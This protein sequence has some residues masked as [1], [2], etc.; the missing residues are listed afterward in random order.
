MTTVAPERRRF[1]DIVPMLLLTLLGVALLFYFTRTGLA[2][3]GD[4]VRYVMGAENLIAGRGYSRTS[5]GGEVYPETGFAPFLAV[6]LA[7]MG[8]LGADMFDGARV[9]NLLLFGLNIL[10]V[11]AMI[12]RHTGSWLAA[13]LGGMLFLAA[14][15]VLESHAWLMTE[16]LF[17][18]VILLSLASLLHFLDTGRI[19]FLILS[20][21]LAGA[22]SV[23]RYIGLSVAPAGALAVLWLGRGPWRARLTQAFGFAALG[24]A[25][26]LV[27][28]LRNQ[29]VADSGLANR[30]LIFHMIRPDL[31]RFYLYEAATWAL[32]DPFVVPRAVRAAIAVALTGLAPAWYFLRARQERRLSLAPTS[33]AFGALPWVFGVN[34]VSYSVV[35]ILNSILLDA[36]TTEPAATRYLVPFFG[37]LVVFETCIYADLARG[38]DEPKIFRG[39]GLG[40]AVVLIALYAQRSIALARLSTFPLGFTRIR[41]SWSAAASDLIRL[42]GDRPI[43]SNN[44]EIV[45]Y[46]VDRPAYFMPILYDPYQQQARP[47]FEAQ[48]ALARQRMM[49]GSVLVIFGEP[50][51]WEA[52]ALERLELVLLAESEDV[53]IYGRPER[54]PGTSSAR[55]FRSPLSVLRED[56]GLCASWSI[57]KGT[58][59]WVG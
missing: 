58:H 14:P 26:F 31:V 25:P 48:L 59:L 47:D 16:A 27:W 4:S 21:A 54:G 30:Q 15:N 17:I 1:R 39:L 57:E 38:T 44:P 37:L 10:L 45:Y 41:V 46:L 2:I 35:L 11:G 5:G 33:A 8:V 52:E 43:I 28:M 56:V 40:I 6:V 34:L 12:Q 18:L 49:E 42:A 3:R 13:F 20:G 19:G 29:A 7:G 23:T 36:G 53:A 55:E 32:P 51:P 50:K 22:A 24:V 9:L